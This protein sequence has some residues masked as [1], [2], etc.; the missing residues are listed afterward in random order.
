MIVSDPVCYS[1]NSIALGDVIA[2]APV[3]KYAINTFHK[4]TD[5]KVLVRP[6]YYD[7]FKPFVPEDKLADQSQPFSYSIPWQ[8]RYLN[9]PRST[10]ARTTSMHMHLST[11]ASIQLLNRLMPEKDLNYLPMT[12]V[13]T[14]HFNIDF[15]KAVL[16]IVTYRD[17]VRKISF[18]AVSEIA[19][20]VKSRGL[21]PV[22]IGRVDSSE[23]WKDSPFRLAFDNLPD[24]IDLLNK[25]S[26]LEMASIMAKSRC[27]V[28]L[29]SG[30]IHVAGT[31]SVPIVCGF[32]NVAPEHRYPIRDRGIFMP[33]VPDLPCSHCQ[34]RWCLN[35]HD[36]G[37]CYF[38]HADCIKQMTADKFIKALGC[39]DL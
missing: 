35:Y 8:I 19:E 39:L 16:I 1:L 23:M 12:K 24:G 13:D 34:S 33:I 31:T 21:L 22:Y 28:G 3:I 4:N 38:K 36:F 9:T 11:F 30:P 6:Y 27:V 7:I 20:W 10:N 29:D 37:Y 14:D 17:E 15:S 32:T 25:T 26:I 5:Y 18:E 2:A